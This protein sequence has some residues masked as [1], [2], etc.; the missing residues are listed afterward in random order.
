MEN[1]LFVE[2][3]HVRH[4][5][6]EHVSLEGA[7]AKELVEHKKDLR[8]YIS[9][10]TDSIGYVV[11]LAV[12]HSKSS[13]QMVGQPLPIHGQINVGESD[14]V[15]APGKTGDIAKAAAQNVRASIKKIFNKIDNPYVSCVV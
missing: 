15:T 7:M 3:K 2:P 6:Q 4:A 9:S 1:S 13:G 8:K 12:T 11:G 5:L 10:M 14:K